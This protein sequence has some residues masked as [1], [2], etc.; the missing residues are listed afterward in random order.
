MS[1]RGVMAS[2]DSEPSLPLGLGI[3]DRTEF[4]NLIMGVGGE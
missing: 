1:C 2:M 4:S 3:W